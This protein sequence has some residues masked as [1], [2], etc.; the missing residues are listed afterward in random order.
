M[1]EMN[2]NTARAL[3]KR[4]GKY[5]KSIVALLPVAIVLVLAFFYDLSKSSTVA[6]G[7]CIVAL[8]C[9]LI[10][11]WAR[12]I[13]AR[14]IVLAWPFAALVLFYAYFILGSIFAPNS[15]SVTASWIAMFG[16]GL[17]ICVYCT[18]LPLRHVKKIILIVGIFS[19]VYAVSTFAVLFVPQI[20]RTIVKTFYHGSFGNNDRGTSQSGLA[21][22]KST[23]AIFLTA[24]FFASFAYAMRRDKSNKFFVV[25]LLFLFAIVLTTKR[26]HLAFVVAIA[27]LCYVICGSR[28]G[29]SRLTK[30]IIVGV[31]LIVALLLLSEVIPQLSSVFNRFSKLADDDTFGNRSY[32]YDINTALFLKNPVFGAGYGAFQDQFFT[33]VKGARYAAAGTT[34]FKGHNV[35]LQVLAEQGIVGAVLLFGSLFYLLY[36]NLKHLRKA[37]ALLMQSRIGSETPKRIRK[38]LTDCSYVLT[39]ITSEILFFLLYCIT[40]NPLYDFEVYLPFLISIGAYYAARRELKA[41]ASVLGETAEVRITPFGKRVVWEG[42][43]LRG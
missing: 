39:F 1:V 27:L 8:F 16:V 15:H 24:G 17:A 41:I 38:K 19:A 9:L 30:G 43:T 37:S 40:G 12:R 32:M 20:G 10:A 26:A 3:Q 29:M 7:L 4:K 21:D 22:H 18:T 34:S 36:I 6:T 28:R 42:V 33:T 35:F 14:D 23:N 11:L 31:I 13:S 2:V 25:P 5:G